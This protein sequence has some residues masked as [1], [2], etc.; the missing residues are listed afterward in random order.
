MHEDSSRQA[1]G[2][3][4]AAHFRLLREGAT[5]DT[6]DDRRSAHQ[7]RHLVNG[8]HR[9]NDACVDSCVPFGYEEDNRVLILDDV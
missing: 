4:V 7:F 3:S 5:R 2:S 8:E 6:V 1:R 9:L